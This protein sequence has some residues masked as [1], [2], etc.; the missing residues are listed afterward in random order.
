MT[1]H[2][3][4]QD[5][6]GLA[7]RGDRL[8]FSVFDRAARRAVGLLAHD[9][10]VDGRCRLEAR[11]GIHDVAGG[12]P[13]SFARPGADDDERF[14][15]VDADPHLEVEPL[16]CCVEIVDR[17]ADGEGGAHGP[18]RVVLVRCRRSE[19]CD[20]RVADEFFHRA[21]EALELGAQA[22]VVGLETGPDVLRIHVLRLRG[23]PDDVAEEDRDQLPLFSDRLGRGQRRA[24]GQ[25]E[26][27]DLRVLLA[28]LRADV[29]ASSV[30]SSSA[31]F[32]EL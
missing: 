3:P 27:G 1:C 28:A 4:D 11:G 9:D 30:T 15:G 5:R 8:G 16:V 6:L 22:G 29:H 20:D 10:A 24:A 17:L 2:F 32:K 21:T 13:F 18:L 25:A 14:T 31:V 19:Q 23:R 12:H 26:L 7:F